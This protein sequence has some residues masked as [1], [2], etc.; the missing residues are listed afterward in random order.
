[1]ASL[2]R[3]VGDMES[4]SLANAVGAATIAQ[5]KLERSNN[6][7]IAAA[8]AMESECQRA[9]GFLQR[10]GREPP[11]NLN[12]LRISFFL[13]VYHENKSP[14]GFRSLLYLRE[15]IT[16]A[17]IMGLHKT[18]AYEF[19]PS[20]EQQMRRRILWLLFITER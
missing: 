16:I 1:M 3:D 7:D 10:D 14:G 11:V 18:A 4:Y 19:L 15:A 6:D 17:Q 2:H 12:A 5:L 9:R 8:A 20:V 13:H